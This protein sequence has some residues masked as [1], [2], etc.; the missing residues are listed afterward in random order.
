MTGT[1]SSAT[2]N[3]SCTP[4]TIGAMKTEVES[5]TDEVTSSFCKFHQKSGHTIRECILFQ[6]K[7]ITERKD[8]IRENNLCYRCLGAHRVA[9]CEFQPRCKTCG[10]KNHVTSMHIYGYRTEKED[11]T[12]K[13]TDDKSK[14]KD[15]SS[16]EELKDDEEK[17]IPSGDRI[18]A[19]VWWPFHKQ[20]SGSF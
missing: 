19:G 20:P 10:N 18:A 1:S 17:E 6:K 16:I 5:T 13:S 3:K 11:N 9:S 2:H 15:E 8:Y 7:P 12:E 14:R 4:K